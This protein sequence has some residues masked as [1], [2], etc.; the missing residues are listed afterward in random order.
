[1]VAPRNVLKING[2]Y[3]DFGCSNMSFLTTAK[4]LKELG[5]ENWMMCL[6]IKHPEFDIT[7]INPWD[8]ELSAEDIGKVIIESRDNLWYYFRCVLK[9]PAK[10]SAIPFDPILTR[11]SHAAIWCYD[12]N[13]DFLLDQPRQTHKTTFITGLMTHA[14]LFDIYNAEIPYLHIK[15]SRAV[16][17]AGILRDYITDGL[18]KYL[19]PWANERR[20]PG[21]KSLK[22]GAHDVS[23]K[24]ISSAESEDKAMDKLR[25]LTLFTAFFDEYEYM[26]FISSIL[27][28]AKPAMHSARENAI[29]NHGKCCIMYASTPGN[30]DSQ[31]GR[32]AQKIIDKTPRFSEKYYDLSEQDIMNMFD[33]VVTED[34]P[35]GVPVTMMYIKFTYKQ[36]RKTEKWV[37]EQY[38][39]AI[40]SGK[41]DEYK[42]GVLQQRYRGSGGKILFQQKDVDYIMTHKREKD[43]E[44]M[45]IKK[46]I[47]YVYKH[48]VQHVDMTAS[49]PYF[50]SEIPYLVG[51]DP[52]SGSGGDNTAIVIVHPYTL[53][54]VGELKNP[55]MGAMDLLRVISQLAIMLPKAL[56]CIETNNLGK[57]IIDF[58]QESPILNRFYYDEK[59]D[60][61]KNVTDVS[62]DDPIKKA[63]EK[64]YIGTYLTSG[65]RDTMINLLKFLVKEYHHLLTTEYVSDDICK[66]T[67]NKSGKVLAE[68]GEHDDIIMAYLHAIYILYYGKN[69]GRFGIDKTLCVYDQTTKILAE[70]EEAVAEKIVDNLIPSADPYQN[71][72]MEDIR[73]DTYNKS[74]YNYQG[75]DDY[76]YKE[77]D[78]NIGKNYEEEMSLSDASFFVDV[79]AY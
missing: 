62:D 79:N 49:V 5:I 11:A 2:K 69:I 27:S 59:L 42:R 64:K 50:D 73:N 48:D 37:D 70:H 72:I 36:L 65:I 28:G 18:P 39:D 63:K 20:L 71:Q 13:I 8:E 32:E 46:Y 66:L 9:I 17:N 74:A 78:Y 38:N 76:G 56:F 68:D 55:Y 77:S 54:V 26:P 34:N 7:S 22:Y 12:H 23:I 40:I 53:E 31:T 10:G 6:E 67:I 45:L 29:K 15:D 47:L 14:I 52:S 19:N 41:I 1:M 60:I 25:G 75:Y 16:D 43:Y 51:I 30:L 35:T 33:G 57:A 3:Y 61:S 21:L 44:V 4:E 58:I 24:I